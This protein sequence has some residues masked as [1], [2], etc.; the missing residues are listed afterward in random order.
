M[1]TALA[2]VW[3][4]YADNVFSDYSPLYARISRAVAA[5]DDVLA[6]LADAPPQSHQ[7]N[8]LLAAAHYVLLGGPAHPLAAIHA[9]ESD[10][11]PGPLFID[12]CLTHR[13]EILELLATRHNNTNEVGRSAVIAPALTAV[14]TRA[15]APLALVDVG[16]SAGLNLLCDRYRIDYGD[17]GATGPVDAPVQIPC[18]VV[19]GV[20]PIEPLVPPIVERVGI[21]RD[22]VDVTDDDQ[23]RWQLALVFPDTNRLPRTRLAL[24]ELRND[25]PRIV[26]GDAV[27]TIGRVLLGLRPDAL[28]VVT[29]TWVVAYFPR[30]HRVAFREQLAEVSHTRPVT[31]ISADGPD[32]ID[33]F[34]GIEAPSH[35]GV[36]A[37]LL[38]L[39][40]FERGEVATETLGFVHPHGLW[41]DWRAD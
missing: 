24:Q 11:A 3:T 23:R 6:L 32:T 1:S 40:R 34:A 8:L 9:R 15:A 41:V 29:T 16:C 25:P 27:E 17:A 7:P 12:V 31:W 18:T 36:E 33:L 30:E 35:N 10:A 22:V 14:G 38:G 5:S 20:P 26:P 13:D 39:A 2:D 21:D 28:A 19:G 37:S 4:W